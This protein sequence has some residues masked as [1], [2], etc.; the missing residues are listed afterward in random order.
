LDDGASALAIA[1]LSGENRRRRAR[2]CN[3]QKLNIQTTLSI[4]FYGTKTMRT[5]LSICLAVSIAFLF[6]SGLSRATLH[7]IGP[8][9][10]EKYRDQQT[11]CRNYACEHGVDK[12]EILG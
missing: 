5:N 9:A 2:T 12:L 10:K 6:A 7:K 11:E 3:G 4:R 8:H 1:T